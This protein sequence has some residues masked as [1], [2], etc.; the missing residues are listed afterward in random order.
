MTI[1]YY[2]PK[3]SSCRATDLS[4]L[5]SMRAVLVHRNP[6][7]SDILGKPCDTHG[8]FSY[9]II[10]ADFLKPVDFSPKTNGFGVSQKPSRVP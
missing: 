10:L 3:K 4:F 9:D 1:T 7:E 2:C 8:D 6:R 5:D